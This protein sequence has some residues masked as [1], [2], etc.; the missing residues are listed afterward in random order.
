MAC[1][2]HVNYRGVSGVGRANECAL[3]RTIRGLVKDCWLATMASN[4]GERLSAAVST[5]RRAWWGHRLEHAD[6]C[7]QKRGVGTGI[8]VD[9]RGW[10]S[11]CLYSMSCTTSVLTTQAPPSRT[12]TPQVIEGVTPDT[13]FIKVV[14]NELI[15]LMGGGVGSKDL[16]P[17]FPQVGAGDGMDVDG[18]ALSGRW[19]VGDGHPKEDA[20][21]VVVEGAV[22]AEMRGVR[23]KLGSRFWGGHGLLGRAGGVTRC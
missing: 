3:R 11:A 15:D 21:R 18:G 4:R 8:E 14:S 20:G 1:T 6:S 10:G 23:L 16:E 13:Q 17:G 2:E 22:G 19:K 12:P 5:W 9:T 7:E